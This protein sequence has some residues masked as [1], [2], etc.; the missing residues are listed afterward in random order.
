MAPRS[1]APR[2][3]WRPPREAATLPQRDPRQGGLAR[4]SPS[5]PTLV[6]HVGAGLERHAPSR[7]AAGDAAGTPP[8][9]ASGRRGG[10]GRG[11]GPGG[12]ALGGGGAG[13]D[14]ARPRPDGA[15]PPGVPEQAGCGA[16]PVLRRARGDGGALRPGRP[17]HPSHHRQDLGEGE[18][19]LAPLGRG[20]PEPGPGVRGAARPRERAGSLHDAVQ[21]GCRGVQEEPSGLAGGVRPVPPRRSG[22]PAPRGDSARVGPAARARHLGPWQGAGRGAAEGP[23]APDP[24]A[25]RDEAR[26]RGGGRVRHQGQHRGGRGVGRADRRARPRRP[27]LARADRR[28]ERLP[29]RS[30]GVAQGRPPRGPGRAGAG[31]ARGRAVP[32]G[33]GGAVPSVGGLRGPARRH[34]GPGAPASR[35]RAPDHAGQ[36]LGP[37]VRA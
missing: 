27:S 7:R 6:R 20:P 29:G 25:W 15:D 28:S 2:P 10:R 18:G 5:P 1:R 37:T 4:A 19:D 21:R 8:G 17:Q 35:R 11:H 13:A 26:R 30:P 33:L 9:A 12:V 23:A 32:A 16:A 14:P 3:W 22:G 36:G 24:P 34:A 31:C